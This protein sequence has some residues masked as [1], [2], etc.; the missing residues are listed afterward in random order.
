[1]YTLERVVAG[2]ATEHVFNTLTEALFALKCQVGL[3]DFSLANGDFVAWFRDWVRQESL[4]TPGA[5]D[6]GEE[7]IQIGIPVVFRVYVGSARFPLMS[8][9]VA[10]ALETLYQRMYK[11]E[12]RWPKGWCGFGP[13]PRTGRSSYRKSRI[14]GLDARKSWD[15][16]QSYPDYPELKPE[17][18]PELHYRSG[19]RFYRQAVE[20]SWK[21]Q[22]KG[23]KAWDTQ[24]I[25]PTAR[26]ARAA[27][28]R[29]TYEAE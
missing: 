8:A 29:D 23:R 19:S 25:Q 20:R 28:L 27:K 24:G 15:I 5:L 12:K 9:E 16:A 26:S 22:H 21:A 11:R 10:A 18:K 1:M 13:V 7:W 17:P 14:L 4:A 2:K 3:S 6:N